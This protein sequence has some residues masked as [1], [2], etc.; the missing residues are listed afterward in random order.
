MQL[1]VYWF[2]EVPCEPFY[3]PVR[4]LREARLVLDALAIYDGFQSAH[5]IKPDYHNAGGLEVFDPED[6]NDGPEGSWCEWYD[7]LDRNIDDLSDAE[8]DE[9]DRVAAVHRATQTE[10]NT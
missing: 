6:D 2:P 3:I 4:T 1:R 9:I 7:D 10:T 8:I 5:R